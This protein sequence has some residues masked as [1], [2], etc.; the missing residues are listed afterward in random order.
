MTD[1]LTI[2]DEDLYLAPDGYSY[3]YEDRPFT[4]VA[5]RHSHDGQL[6]SEIHYV[7]G[8]LDGDAR[9]WYPSGERLR[10]EHFERNSHTGLAREWYRDGQLQRETLFDHSIR[11]REQR[12]D[13]RGRL[14]HDFVLTE[15]DPLFRTLQTLRGT[16]VGQARDEGPPSADSAQRTDPTT[17]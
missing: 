10:E 17:A 3:E 2:D 15:G 12:W 4:G 7:D 8:M 9:Y 1:M 5:L 14:V 11:L 16:K 6:V 13:E